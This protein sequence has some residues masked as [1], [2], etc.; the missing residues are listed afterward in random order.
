M[1]TPFRPNLETLGS[2]ELPSVAPFTFTLADGTVVSGTFDYDETAVDATLASQQVPVSDVTVALNG[3]PAQLAAE[4]VVPVATFALGQFQA[5]SLTAVAVVGDLAALLDTA[6][7][8]SPISVTNPAPPLN[9]ITQPEPGVGPIDW[10]AMLASYNANLAAL[11]AAKNAIQAKMA[12][13]DV[14]KDLY[15]D[16]GA[17]QFTDPNAAMRAIYQA[18]LPAVK[19][20]LVAKEGELFVAAANYAALYQQVD[21]QYALLD[22][23]LPA[24]LR[25]Q[26]P[27]MPAFFE[28][29]PSY[30]EY[31]W[32]VAV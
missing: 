20:Q 15:L 17:R 2:R 5:V 19:A 29:P 16:V 23:S 8:L 6:G 24:E 31:Y 13:H 18:L 7:T 27:N 26:L 21:I 9:P 28:L 4:L 14:L 10:A 22:R 11:A 12:E 3:Q 25:L 1:P 30:L 32:V